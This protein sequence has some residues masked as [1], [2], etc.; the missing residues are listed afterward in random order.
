M[1]TIVVTRRIVAAIGFLV[2]LGSGASIAISPQ[3]MFTE[4]K[5][6]KAITNDKDRLKCFDRLF[7]EPSNPQ[8]PPEGA[9][10][11]WS[12]EESKSP[13]DGSSQLVAANLVGDTVLIL[14]CKDQ[15]TEVAFRRS[16]IILAINPLTYNCGSMNK[17]Q[18]KKSGRR[19]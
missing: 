18:Q 16:T 9:Q 10:E 14:R 15:I 13:T 2:T 6:C 4:A 11:N 12:I 17:A 3:D 5:A 8:N 1:R 19:Q 7:T